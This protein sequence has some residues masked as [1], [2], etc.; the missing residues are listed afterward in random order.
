METSLNQPKPL[1]F[2]ALVATVIASAPLLGLLADAFVE[3]YRT[4]SY[5]LRALWIGSIGF[6]A[7]KLV[8]NDAV[9]AVEF[10]FVAVGVIGL[11]GFMVSS[12]QLCM[13]Q[14]HDASSCDIKSIIYLHYWTYCTSKLTV[15]PMCVVNSPDL[16]RLIPPVVLTLALCSES[17]LHNLIIKEPGTINPLKLIFKV[18]NYA[19]KN[20]HPRLRKANT[21]WEDKPYSR[22]DL[23]KDKYGGPFSTEEVEDVKTFFRIIVT[24]SIPAFFYGY[25]IFGDKAVSSK[26]A[27]FQ[28]NLSLLPNDSIIFQNDLAFVCL[29][30]LMFS[31][32]GEILLALT[33]PLRLAMIPMPGCT[34]KILKKCGIG[35]ALIVL[36]LVVVVSQQAFQQT[37][38][39]RNETTHGNKLSTNIESNPLLMVGFSLLTSFGEMLV[40]ISCLE[41]ICAQSPYSMKSL[42]WGFSFLCAGV[43]IGVVNGL[44]GVFYKINPRYHGLN[45]DFW[46]VLTCTLFAILLYSVFVLVSVHY[47]ERKRGDNLPSEHYFAEE[48]YEKLLD[49]SSRD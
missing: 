36:C 5:S 48:Y 27:L 30:R 10:L 7:T 8:T 17:Q 23:G 35:L 22:I 46:F 33:I 1:I 9:F 13:D 21:Y 45:Y 2:Q 18:L 37:R 26:Q 19:R 38:A 47:K 28:K 16:L 25:F 43:S 40:S 44:K 3:R 34:M 12:V 24:I 6:S 49:A 31:N 15:F 39:S 14:F 41:F 11:A 4:V 42:L 29:K 20:K 32:M